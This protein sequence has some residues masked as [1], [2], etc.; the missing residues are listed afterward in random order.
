MA[1]QRWDAWVR[2]GPW[3]SRLKLAALLVAGLAAGAAAQD[4]LD[5][6][7][8]EFTVVV[9]DLAGPTDAVSREFSVIILDEAAPAD[10]VS[11]EWTVMVLDPAVVTDAVSREFTFNFEDPSAT[12][13]AISRELTFYFLADV[14]LPA[15]YYAR[16][17]TAVPQDTIRIMA[18]A[19]PPE[20]SAFNA[21]LYVTAAGGLGGT[22]TDPGDDVLYRM[23]RSGDLEALLTF[24]DARTDPV[25]A[26][27]GQGGALGTDLLVSTRGLGADNSGAV[28][29]VDRL[30]TVAVLTGQLQD[31]PDPWRITVRPAGIAAYEDGAYLATGAPGP[32]QLVVVAPTGQLGSYVLDHNPGLLC[33]Q[34]SPSGEGGV[35]H[36]GGADHIIYRADASG[37]LTALTADLGATIQALAFG[38]GLYPFGSDL[39]A[40]LEDGRIVRVDGSGTVTPF[41]G[42]LA[43]TTARGSA[44]V[45][46]LCFSA[47]GDRLYVTD[48]GRK[49]IYALQ[50]EPPTGVEEGPGEI[51]KATALDGIYPNPFNPG[52]NVRFSLKREC[53]VEIAIYDVRG[54]MVR[55]LAAGEIYP[56]GV[57]HLFWDGKDDHGKGSSSGL[58]MLVMK[59]DGQGFR[60]KMTLLK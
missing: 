33:A 42:G 53:P 30:E 44:V 5:A 18:L 52:T 43:T 39:F 35:L 10:A 55:T 2:W 40:L 45:N 54:M 8:R 24:P 51:P 46:D 21:D 16:E 27:F 17:V 60:Q 31:Y 15:G 11:R 19:V 25:G 26:A 38:R 49:R 29:K 58:Y 6:V 50:Y 47:L 34:F 4:P 1:R 20:P 9:L 41:I 48:A 14:T 13:D 32:H 23:F 28:V 59:A 22:E 12:A 37:Q 7:S 56:A 36:V 57:H 3:R